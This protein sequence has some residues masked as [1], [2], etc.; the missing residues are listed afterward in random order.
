MLEFIEK[1]CIDALEAY[2][3]TGKADFFDNIDDN[4]VWYGTVSY[5]VVIGKAN[6]LKY[7]NR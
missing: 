7:F 6:L 1:F 5:Q 3:N 4:V 2:Y